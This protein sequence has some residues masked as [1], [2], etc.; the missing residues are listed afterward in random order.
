MYK[1]VITAFPAAMLMAGAAFAAPSSSPPAQPQ[2]SAVSQATSSSQYDDA[3]LVK[4][5]QA[6]RAARQA[7]KQDMQQI[8]TASNPNTKNQLTQQEKRDMGAAISKYM[9]V[10][11]YEQILRDARHDPQLK[12]RIGKLAKEYRSKAMS[13]GASTSGRPAMTPPPTH[14][15][16]DATLLKFALATEAAAKVRREYMQKIKA[17]SDPQ[18][19]VQIKAQGKKEMGAAITKYMPI[20]QY[21][22]IMYDVRHDPQ[23]KARVKKLAKEHRQQSASSG[24]RGGS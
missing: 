20:S 2:P 14:K 1:Y 24:S 13:G 18:T 22:Q 5:L 10:S 6:T 9:P 11:Q 19:E 16:D 7:R 4:F 8:G 17:T 3:T 23:L 15:Y 21:E 12:E